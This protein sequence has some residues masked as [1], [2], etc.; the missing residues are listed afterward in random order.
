MKRGFILFAICVGSMFPQA[1]E[2]SKTV[3]LQKALEQRYISANALCT[4]GLELRYT[5]SNLLNDSLFV[6]VP[7]GWRFNSDA[8]KSDYQDI[9]IT[10]Q[11][12]LVMKARETRRFTMKGFCCEASKSGPVAG[13]PYTAGKMAD[14]SLVFLARYLNSHPIDPN[15]QQYAVWAVSDRRETANITHKNDSLAGELRSFVAGIKGEPLPWY[16]LL[17]K[18]VVTASGDVN[19]YPV[20]FNASIPYAVAR[21]CYSYCYLVDA[22]GNTVSEI[23]GKWLQ[24]QGNDYRASFNV[25]GLKKGEYRLILESKEASLFERSFK[26]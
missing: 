20:R 1:L 9:L 18:A 15:T 2:A 22:K 24:P 7:A 4:G 16:T 21:E 25:A 14:S 23:F 3:T 17:K 8:G 10:R 26:I 13:V 5:V 19:D 6:S 12:V 11:E